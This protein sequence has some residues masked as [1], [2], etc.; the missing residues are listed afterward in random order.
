MQLKL[1][2]AGA[3]Y[4]VIRLVYSFNGFLLP[5]RQVGFLLLSVYIGF[6]DNIGLIS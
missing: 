4:S 2:S 5:L 6:H 1:T 3:F